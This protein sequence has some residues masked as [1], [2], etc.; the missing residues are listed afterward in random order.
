MIRFIADISHWAG[1][2]D[3]TG[4]MDSILMKS[5]KELRI[6]TAKPCSFLTH[7]HTAQIM[8]YH[9]NYPDQKNMCL[10]SLWS[11]FIPSLLDFTVIPTSLFP[12]LHLS[13]ST[14][15]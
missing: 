4:L 10:V 15:P 9:L 2:Y 5:T 12:D 3:E 6:A 14:N 7:K 13:L 8:Q 11:V 1:V